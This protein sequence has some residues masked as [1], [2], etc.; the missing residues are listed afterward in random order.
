MH[1]YIVSGGGKYRNDTEDYRKELES[2]IIIFLL[3]V[4]GKNNFVTIL[5][6]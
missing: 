5:G 6:V 1:K 2:E 3:N 4:R